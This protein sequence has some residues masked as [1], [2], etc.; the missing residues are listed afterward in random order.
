MRKPLYKVLI[1]ENSTGEVVESFDQFSEE[2]DEFDRD[3]FWWSE[4]SFSCDCNRY[5]EFY[6]RK[7]G[8]EPPQKEYDEIRCGDEKYS[9]RMTRLDTG[10]VFYD[11]L[12]EERK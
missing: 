12:E 9:V 3:L 1:R 6:R 5:L 4:G 2:G 10:E 11:E 7:H 8:E